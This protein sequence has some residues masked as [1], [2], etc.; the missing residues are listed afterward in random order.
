MAPMKHNNSNSSSNNYYG[1]DVL[2]QANILASC[3]LVDPS[4]P[5]LKGLHY[6]TTGLAGAEWYS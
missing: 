4:L 1:E 5:S 2:R 3:Y 6:C